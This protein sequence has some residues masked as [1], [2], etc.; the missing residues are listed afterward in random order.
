MRTQPF[1]LLSARVRAVVFLSLIGIGIGARAQVFTLETNLS[2]VTISGS[3]I[4]GVISNQGPG[5]LTTTIGGSIQVQLNGSSIQFIGQSEILAETN[6]SWQPLADGS[7]GS[8]LADFGGTA[9]TAFASGVAALRNVQLDLISPVI[10]LSGGQ[11]DSTNLTFLFPSNALSSLAYNATGLLSK[12]GSIA[13]TGYATNRVT[14]LS[15]LTTAGSQ[16]TLTIPVDATFYLKVLSANDTVIRLQ[17][18]LMA[19]QSVQAPLTVQSIA[20]Q[21]QSLLI[22]WQASPG[23]Q[24]Q[25]QSSTNLTAWRTNATVTTSSSGVYT[26]TGSI[27]GPLQFLRL[28]K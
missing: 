26:W 3:V 25:I 20:V 19:T 28:A 1:K 11:F 10:N 27:S 16:Q 12:H 24:F 5:S 6:G 4:G 23:A 15:T 2:T 13:L 7:A 9:S 8:A 21:N 18:Q 17:G 22:K 14:A